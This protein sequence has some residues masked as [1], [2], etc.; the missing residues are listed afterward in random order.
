MAKYKSVKA[1]RIGKIFEETIKT[2]VDFNLKENMDLSKKHY[3]YGATPPL[4]EN[5][6]Q[7]TNKK[8]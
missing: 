1:K 5:L 7:I 8:K 6:K 3:R 4:K 2:Y